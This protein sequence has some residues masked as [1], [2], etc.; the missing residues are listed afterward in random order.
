MSITQD[1]LDSSAGS[2]PKTRLHGLT[3]GDDQ[4]WYREGL[5]PSRIYGLL[6]YP[7]GIWAASVMGISLFDGEKFHLSLPEKRSYSDLDAFITLNRGRIRLMAS[8]T[9]GQDLYY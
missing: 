7:E 4:L 1:S 8:D 3:D 9:A 6:E 5:P 2:S